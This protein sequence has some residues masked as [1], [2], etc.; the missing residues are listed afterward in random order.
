MTAAVRFLSRSPRVR[1]AFLA[2]TA[3]LAAVVFLSFALGVGATPDPIPFEETTTTGLP[4]EERQAAEAGDVT[5]PRAQ[6]FYSQY[7]FVVGYV[8]I[9]HAVDTLQQPEH[10]QQFGYPVAVWVS[11]F[12]DTG[13]TLTEDGQPQ[14]AEEPG[15]VDATATHF[16]VDSDARTPAGETAIPF[17]SESAASS[18]AEEHDGQ[19]VDWATVQGYEFDIDHATAVR[20]RV[21]DQ[22]READ[23]RVTAARE[24]ADREVSVVVGEDVSTIQDGIDAAEPDTAVLV[25]EG[26]YEETL[27]VDRPI[28]LRGGGASIVGDGEGPVV[29]I[30]S[31]DV[32]VTGVEIEG[33]GERMRPDE[34]EVD[35]D[36]WDGSVEAGYGH[37]D[38]G[39]Q[40]VNVSGT[41]VADVEIE[42]PTHGVLLRDADGVVERIAVEGSEEWAEGFM[43][44][45][46]LR[47]SVVVQDSEFDA[48]RDGVYLHRGHDTVVRNN[49]FRDNRFGVHLMYTS[50]T[51]VAD[52]VAR[53]Q[54]SAGVVI[55]TSPARNA[56]VG[57]DIRDSSTGIIPGGSRAYVAENV[58]ANNERGLTTGST[59]S[60]YERNVVYGNDLGIEI[61]TIRPTN[62]VVEN[63]FVA[64]DDTV[65]VGGLGPLTVWTHDGVGNYWDGGT[66]SH[67]EAGSYS[68]SD[69]VEGQFRDTPGAVTL[70]AS[71]AVSALDAVRDT[72]PGMREGAV[73]DT[74]PRTEPVQPDVIAELEEEYDD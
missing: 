71:P 22:Q 65:R 11:D 60:L 8:G 68:P 50:D 46:A 32:A 70:S 25:P 3:L 6:V 4:A 51:L 33:V 36:Q 35:D 1:V 57:N 66:A 47:E 37:A 63:D 40:A 10:E 61:G 30:E 73:V 34:G 67:R 45:I 31:D 12:T 9:E 56:V 13:V 59:Q 74:A 24:T 14:T 5:V 18:F 53:G 2:A 55:M 19:V 21:G 23:D 38:A 26:T 16:V 29:E 49:T 20:D 17:A 69:P 27:T 15:W 62:R 39:I 52:N 7:Q 28:T 58:L 44:V 42:T 64:N 43:G 72:T 54:S 48:G 41:Y